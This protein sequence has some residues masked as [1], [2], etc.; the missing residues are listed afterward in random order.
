MVSEITAAKAAGPHFRPAWW[1]SAA[2]P[3]SC[4]LTGTAAEDSRGTAYF[5]GTP[6][7]VGDW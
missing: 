3:E 4:K 7:F 1:F 6:H 2:A 5:S